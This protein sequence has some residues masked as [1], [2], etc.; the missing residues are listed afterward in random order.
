MSDETVGNQALLADVVEHR[1]LLAVLD[2]WETLRGEAPA[3]DVDQLDPEHFLRFASHLI[4][5]DVVSDTDV[6]FRIAGESIESVFGRQLKGLKLS[7][8]RE[9]VP[10]REPYEQ[11]AECIRTAAPHYYDGPAVAFDKEFLRARRLLL[12]FT[13]ETGAVKRMIVAAIYGD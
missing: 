6:A 8:L 2:V 4:V 1:T 7:E 3:P 5:C 12:P 13:D 9:N 11:F 10:N